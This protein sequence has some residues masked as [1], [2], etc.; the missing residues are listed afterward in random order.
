MPLYEAITHLLE[1]RKMG[2]SASEKQ[3]DMPFEQLDKDIMDI[4]FGFCGESVSMVLAL[5][6]FP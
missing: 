5:N 3:N 1:T 6:A 4:H 2:Y